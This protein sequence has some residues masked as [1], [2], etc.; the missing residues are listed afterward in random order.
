L[1]KMLLSL[2]FVLLLAGCDA[3]K[4]NDY[5]NG[6]DYGEGNGQGDEAAYDLRNDRANPNFM[7]NRQRQYQVEDDITD[8]NPNFLNLRREGTDA[9]DEDQANRNNFGNDIDTARD[10]VNRS[11]DF[12]A[13]SVFIN[14]NGDR[15]SVTVNHRGELSDRES[16]NAVAEL[17]RKL[18]T[19]L[20]RYFIEVKVR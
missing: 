10:I 6:N 8:R 5:G 18:N 15:M 4:G 19:A 14:N 16:N 13:D 9:G 12:R 3:G 20:P 2:L 11:G 7:A 17:Q 1:K